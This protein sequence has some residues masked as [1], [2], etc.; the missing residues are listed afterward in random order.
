MGSIVLCGTLLWLGAAGAATGHGD[1]HGPSISDLTFPAIN[2]LLF[3]FLLRWA[4]GGAIRDYLAQRREEIVAALQ[5]ATAAKE[6]ATRAHS[7]ARA[8]LA[9]VDEEL[10][11]LRDDMRSVAQTERDRR[12]KL[13]T[14]VASRVAA[15]ARLVAEQEG[16]TARA[17]LQQET[18]RAAVAETIAL[19]RRQIKSA[20]QDRFMDE[21]ASGVQ[22]QA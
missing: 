18:V 3:I 6:T 20:D 5:D 1:A 22:A 17:A 16:R 9:R 2:F 4:G 14:E 19:L 11:R 8:H 12:L 13:A 15:D 7:D 10:T 21:F